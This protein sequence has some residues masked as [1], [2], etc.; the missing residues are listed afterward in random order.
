MKTAKWT[1][2]I[3][4]H[5]TV[6]NILMASIFI[7]LQGTNSGIRRSLTNIQKVIRPGETSR[8]TTPWTAQAAPGSRP[9]PGTTSTY[10]NMKT[11]KEIFKA[12]GNTFYSYEAV[13]EYTEEN[14]FI[15]TNTETTTH[16]GIKIYVITLISRP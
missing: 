13:L 7:T 11:Q 16:K 12:N 4:H 2:R 15:I 3:I 6:T 14:N 8:S 1:S 5:R 10:N 9:G